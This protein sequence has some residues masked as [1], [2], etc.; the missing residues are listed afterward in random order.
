M[1]K[2]NIQ[3]RKGLKIVGEVHI[4]ENPSGLA[5]VEHGLGGYKEQISIIATTETLFKNNYTVINFDATNS[6]GESEG[7]YEDATTQLHYE[8]L[9]DVIEWAKNEAWY[10]EPFI[11]AGSS[12]GGYAVIRYA[13]ENPNKV[14]AVFAKAPM[15]AGEFTFLA[16]EKFNPEVLKS[17]KE[18]G[19]NERKS[20]S[21]QGLIKRLPWS[22]MEERLNHDLR[23]NASKLT[24]PIL[25]V[26]GDKDTSCPADI[27]QILYDLLP[28]NPSNELHIL[29]DAPHTFREEKDLNQLKSILDKWLKKLN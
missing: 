2:F 11:L 18:T 9:V 26:V 19:W 6:V 23:P 3:N 13:E 16:N 27:Q 5:F 29:K 4:P 7:K 20:V 10:K 14:K 15:V 21:K 24:M 22:H 28:T 12:L 25:L 1:K 8:D 17:W